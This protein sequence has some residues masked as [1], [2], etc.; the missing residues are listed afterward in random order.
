M[1]N[2]AAVRFYSRF[3]TVW[4]ARD[5]MNVPNGLRVE[6]FATPGIDSFLA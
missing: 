5:C 3:V 4:L 6:K 1:L 2:K